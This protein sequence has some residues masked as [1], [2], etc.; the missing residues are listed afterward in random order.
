[1]AGTK[2]RESDDVF[3][4]EAQ[5]ETHPLLTG[6]QLGVGVAPCGIGVTPVGVGWYLGTGVGEGCGY[7]WGFQDGVP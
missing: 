4:R 3:V 7:C 1:M 2:A 5:K 6:Y